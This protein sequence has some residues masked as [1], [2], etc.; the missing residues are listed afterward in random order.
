MYGR[1]CALIAPELPDRVKK[2][3]ERFGTTNFE[4]VMA[5]LTDGAWISDL[6]AGN[7]KAGEEMRG[8][9]EYVEAA[10][11]KTVADRQLVRP[12]Y[13]PSEAST[14]SDSSRCPEHSA[15]IR[16]VVGLES[17]RRNPAAFNVHT[18]GP[19]CV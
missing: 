11:L 19:S 4:R 14:P 18:G 2:M 5:L 6:Y 12:A 10:L 13:R 8:D 16:A 17:H 15:P 9:P 7:A 1:R 3:F